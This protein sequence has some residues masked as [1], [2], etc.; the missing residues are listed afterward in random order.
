MVFELAAKFQ[1]PKAEVAKL[2]LGVK[3]AIFH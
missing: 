2:A 1:I 3:A